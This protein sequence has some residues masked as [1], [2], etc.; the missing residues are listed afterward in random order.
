ML[1]KREGEP[2]QNQEE[3]GITKERKKRLKE[4]KTQTRQG[5]KNKMEKFKS[6]IYQGQSGF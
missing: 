2:Q 4:R 1:P 3:R 6:M 5:R